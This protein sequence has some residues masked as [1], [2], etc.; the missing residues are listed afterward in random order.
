MCVLVDWIIGKGTLQ[1]EHAESN[2]LPIECARQ[3][4]WKQS[5]HPPTQMFTITVV[6]MY[7]ILKMSLWCIGTG[8]KMTAINFWFFI[9]TA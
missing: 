1:L 4:L 9:Q 5:P 6:W 2:T 8:I 7:V 3:A